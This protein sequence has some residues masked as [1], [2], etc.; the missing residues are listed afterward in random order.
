[1][2]LI[3]L[4]YA[5]ID[6]WQCRCCYCC[7]WKAHGTGLLFEPAF[8]KRGES[9]ARREKVESSKCLRRCCLTHC[10]CSSSCRCCITALHCRVLRCLLVPTEILGSKRYAIASYNGACLHFI[11]F[12]RDPQE[13]DREIQ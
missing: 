13:N 2:H 11:Q 4:L 8:S 3:A 1:M 10:L 6:T 9:F 7:L 12:P 5:T